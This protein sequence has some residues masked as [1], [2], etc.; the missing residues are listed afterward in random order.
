MI[1]PRL[2]K[3]ALGASEIARTF[4]KQQVISTSGRER[5]YTV[6]IDAAFSGVAS[7]IPPTTV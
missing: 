3:E 2:P 5:P 4:A 6:L 7:V 1:F